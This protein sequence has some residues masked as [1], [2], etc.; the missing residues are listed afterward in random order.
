MEHWWNYDRAKP[1]Y[2]DKNMSQCYFVH[3]NSHIDRGVSEDSSDLGCYAIS[4]GEHSQ[5]TNISKDHSAF[6]FKAKQSKKG[7]R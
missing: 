4:T 5:L 7:D 1:K 3:H 2:S 6:N